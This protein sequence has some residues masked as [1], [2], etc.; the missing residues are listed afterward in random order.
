[1]QCSSSTDRHIGLDNQLISQLS[2]RKKINYKMNV[3]ADN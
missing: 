2:G 3:N 1:M